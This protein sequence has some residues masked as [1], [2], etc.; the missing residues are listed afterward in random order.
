MPGP[1]YRNSIRVPKDKKGKADDPDIDFGIF[2]SVEDY[3]DTDLGP[4]LDQEPLSA[5]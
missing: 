1:K 4:G 5:R 3:Y 2:T